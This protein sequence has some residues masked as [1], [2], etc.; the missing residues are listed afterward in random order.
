MK[1]FGMYVVKPR[2]LYIG[3]IVSCR[4]LLR[5]S[6]RVAVDAGCCQLH[7]EKK[8]DGLDG[9]MCGF[10]VDY[11][12]QIY[13]FSAERRCRLASQLLL[14][15]YDHLS[16]VFSLKEKSTH[17]VLSNACMAKVQA[18]HMRC[19]RRILS[20]MCNDF[21]PNVESGRHIWLGQYHQRSSFAPIRIIRPRRQ[22]QS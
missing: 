12:R 9:P 10:I 5:W 1:V 22:M 15:G 3:A 2:R 4:P 19:Q 11:C 13:G 21:I 17:A 8:L 20:I 6:G 18:L 14:F 16:C 7:T